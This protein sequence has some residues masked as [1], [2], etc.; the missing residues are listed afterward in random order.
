VQNISFA[1][2]TEQVRYGFATGEILKDVTRRI[3]WLNLREGMKLRACVKCMGLKKGQKPEVLGT[4]AV[5]SVRREP[6]LVIT[7]DEVKREGFPG[8]S[9]KWFIKLFA[10]TH[11]DPRT[12]APARPSTVVTRI[13]FRYVR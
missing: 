4:I 12:K 2:T 6:L 7:P 3:G 1:L 8:K 11:K 9:P 13:E 5:V 10:R